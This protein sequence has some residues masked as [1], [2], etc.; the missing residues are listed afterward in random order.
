MLFR[1]EESAIPQ[2]V[3]REA[4]VNALAHR[5][6]EHPA[7]VLVRMFDD[8]LEISNPG[9]PTPEEWRDIT[10]NW[11]PVHRNPLIYDFLRPMQLGEGAGQGIPEMKRL[12]S[13]RGLPEPQFNQ[14][15]DTFIITIFNEPKK[16][17]KQKVLSELIEF[18]AEKKTVSS[19][20]ILKK[21]KISRPHAIRLLKELEAKKYLEHVGSGRNSHY[22]HAEN[23]SGK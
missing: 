16:E 13:E 2:F 4:V 12:L 9:A 19:T 14:I 11:L 23:R 10:A 8:R 22:E 7:E 17:G 5:D 1:S 6:Y 15:Q 18:I 20:D 3:I 21:F